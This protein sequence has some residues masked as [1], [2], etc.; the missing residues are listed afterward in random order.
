MDSIVV[1]LLAAVPILT[2]WFMVDF[3][4]D[5][6]LITLVDL[7]VMYICWYLIRS[8][9]GKS[10]EGSISWELYTGFHPIYAVVVV[11]AAIV[12]FIFMHTTAGKFACGGFTF[13]MP[14]FKDS[15][16][17]IIYW[18]AF[19]ILFV[20]GVPKMEV[21]LYGAYHHG[22]FGSDSNRLISAIILGLLAGLKSIWLIR[23]IY[24][25]CGADLTWLI[26]L[27]LAVQVYTRWAEDSLAVRQLT[28]ICIFVGALLIYYQVSFVKHSVAKSHPGN[29]WN[30]WIK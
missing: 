19:F 17:S 9:L 8:I 25:S 27:W 22:V 6:I 23:A 4:H 11:A 13:L 1:Y 26:I 20:L 21:M 5:F 7:V 16:V 15:W 3:T 28:N 30:K 29:V 10:K 12:Y 24:Q 2:N 18:I 14:A